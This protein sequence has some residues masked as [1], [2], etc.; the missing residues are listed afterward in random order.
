LDNEFQV[1]RDMRYQEYSNKKALLEIQA[2]LSQSLR[3]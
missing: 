2:R 1:K 3:L